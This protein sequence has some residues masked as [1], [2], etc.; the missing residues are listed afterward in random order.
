MGLARDNSLII[1][2]TVYVEFA[3][4]AHEI[5]QLKSA[6]STS[7]EF[8]S[9]DGDRL[10][11]NRAYADVL[12][13]AGLVTFQAMMNG[14]FGKKRPRNGRHR[15][16]VRFELEQGG[17]RQAFYIKR[18]RRAPLKEYWTN[19]IRLR[20]PIV[21]A[22]NEWIAMIR[23]H[24]LGVPT[25]VP[26]A[27]GKSGHESFVITRALEGYDKLSHWIA[28]QHQA[29]AGP[30][31]GR[32]RRVIESV[33]RLARTMHGAGM[34]HQDFYLGHLLLSP[35]VDGEVHIIDLHRVRCCGRLSQH[36]IVKDLA[37]LHYSARVVRRADRIRFL[38]HYLGRRLNRRDR[39][40][41]RKIDRKCRAIE[42]HVEKKRPKSSPQTDCSKA[43]A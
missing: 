13:A 18:H 36:W 9:W 43:A 37:E 2:N 39:A 41:L 33:A 40:L 19:W 8:D 31:R 5:I 14:D 10:I 24:Q 35:E 25:M 6:Q 17:S 23:F 21:S 3:M 29:S 38:R 34:H 30:D 4:P 11:V 28:N 27:F 15:N 7:F 42:S 32:I 16:T 22:D 1:Q 26:V 20:R 12:S